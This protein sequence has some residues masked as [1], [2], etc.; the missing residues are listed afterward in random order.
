MTKRVRLSSS[1][2]PVYPYEDESSSQHPFINPGFISSNGFTQ[3]PDGVL[4]LKCLS[5]LTTTG[6]SL[7]LKV[8]GGLS[9]DDT[10]GSL[11]ENISITA[12]LNKT[13]HSI[14]LSIGDGLETKNNQL[15]A[16]LGDGLT[17]NT[18]SICIDTDINTL[19]TGAT[20][21]ANCLVLGTESND[22]K[23]TL[24][25]V[26]SGALVNAYVALVGASDAVNDLTTETSAQIIADIYFDA[27]GKL[28]PDLSA[29]KTELKHKSGQGTSTADPNN[30]KSFMPSLNAYPLRPNGGNGNYIYG[31]TY[32]RARDETLYELKTSVMLNYKITSGLCAYAMHFQWSWNSGTKPEDT[33]ATFIASPFVFSYIREDD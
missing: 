2:N 15:C 3:S 7:Q 32:Y 14:G 11:E 17:F 18:G 29:L 5:P 12:P 31:T 24:A 8:G 10:D 30:C 16:K 20:P 19:W 27:Q 1:F 26:K 22:C 21:D 9:V 23:L 33:P 13:S 25:L 4:T 28:L 6:G